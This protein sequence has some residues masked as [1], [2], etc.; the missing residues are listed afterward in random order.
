MK[1]YTREKRFAEVYNDRENYPSLEAVARALGR[2]VKTVKNYAGIL[3]SRRKNDKKIPEL[4]WRMP[5]LSEQDEKPRISPAGHAKVRAAALAG[6]MRTLLNISDYPVINPEA[7]VVQERIAFRYDRVLG[8]HVETEATPRTWL[9]DT[10]R[11]A[12]IKNPKGRRFLFSGAQNDAPVDMAFWANLNAYAKK[13]GAEIIVGPW[14]YETNWWDENNPASRDYDPVL[15]KHLCF[16][17][18]EIGG[19]FVFC[20][21]MNTLP[22]ASRPISDLTTYSCGRW[23]VFPHARLQLIS[24]PSTD[25][26]QAHQIM[27]TGA[28]TRPRVIP[29]KAGVK[30][31]FHQVMGA[32]LVEFD[33]DGDIFPRQINA[34]R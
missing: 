26:S 5:M 11:V 17:Q 24:V 19:D 16:G 3:R 28:V 6:E 10:L 2:S 23:A 32:T 20:G 15:Q 14:T 12:P 33:D 30:S 13:I 34:A 27:T 25:G 4:Q 1:D 22:T 8:R 29:R 7:M 21:E 9:T 18:M 31:I